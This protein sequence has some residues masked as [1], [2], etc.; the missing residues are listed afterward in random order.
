[1]EAIVY[2]AP[3]VF[4]PKY[5]RFKEAFDLINLNIGFSVKNP[6]ELKI[7]CITLLNS[8]LY[9][10]KSAILEYFETYSGATDKIY[11]CL[12]NEKLIL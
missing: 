1:L 10:Y 11:T 6:E 9:A 8:D 5:Q 7:K 4:G 12:L 3:V 2:G